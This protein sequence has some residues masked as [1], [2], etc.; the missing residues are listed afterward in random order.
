MSEILREQ[1]QWRI[2]KT[3]I[4]GKYIGEHKKLFDEIAGRGFLNLPGYAY[5]AENQL[6]L[7]AKMG[8]SELNYK[9]MHETIERELKQQGIDYNL[10][11]RNAAM[12]WEVE[13]QALMAAWDAELAGIKQG[14]ATEEEILNRLAQEIAAR[15]IYL[16]E[17]KTEI[18]LKM[19]GYRLTLAQLDG[20]TA[21][22]EVQLANAK[23]LTAQKKLEVIPILQEIISKER[24]LLVLEQGKAIEYTALMNIEGQ[25]ADKQKE[26][27]PTLQTIISKEREL[28]A[29]EAGKA[30]EYTTLVGVEGQIADK[31]KEIIPTLQTIISKERE[32]LALEA[33]KAAEY[34]TLVG[35]EGQ[36]ADKQG[37]IITAL[38]NV[39]AKEYELL[40]FEEQK[41]QE[42][43][44]LLQA[45]Q[46]NAIKK[47][48]LVP[49]YLELA[50]LNQ[51]YAGLIPGQL[52]IEMQIAQEKIAQA[53]AVNTKSENQ[54]DELNSEIDAA[55]ARIS[56][57]EAER[58]VRDER[59]NTEQNLLK[60]D[61]INENIY[62]SLSDAFIT[63]LI[64]SNQ[65]TQ[66]FVNANKRTENT[67]RNAIRK[68]STETIT[69]A[70]M[71]ADASANS[72]EITKTREVAIINAAANITA[73]LRHLIG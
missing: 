8:L 49:W 28:L 71:N 66:S 62:Q 40:P 11:H 26:I 37:E 12:A 56:A 59:F 5:D 9:I 35:V 44:N 19:E 15:Q 36:I 22:Y 68:T 18:D 32:L 48:L 60:D 27:I 14:I 73:S 54:L 61:L 55:N 67:A 38:E 25:I 30:A 41:A 53:Q 10:Q 69:Q 33:G 57:S 21:P 52:G 6:E 24:E 42:Y 43:R 63:A 70:S 29:L 17:A 7:A 23:V 45:K 47:Q 72:A 1:A 16:I 39:I 34:T 31:Q 13:K 64:A 20:Q 51:A 2:G 58:Q 4:I 50:N 65:S 46:E 3:P